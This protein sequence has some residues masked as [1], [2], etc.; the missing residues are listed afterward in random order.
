MKFWGGDQFWKNNSR[1]GR[2]FPGFSGPKRGRGDHQDSVLLQQSYK[3]QVPISYRRNIFLDTC[4]Y[5][6]IS[7]F[8]FESKEK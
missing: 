3:C 7:I 5:E 4:T 1:G 6:I 2:D 8:L